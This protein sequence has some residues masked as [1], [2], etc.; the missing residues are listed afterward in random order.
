MLHVVLLVG[1]VAASGYTSTLI[2]ARV[3]ADVPTPSNPPRRNFQSRIVPVTPPIEYL[4]PTKNVR[5]VVEG[6]AP[7]RDG[8]RARYMYRQ[9]ATTYRLF[10]WYCIPYGKLSCGSAQMVSRTSSASDRAEDTREVLLMTITSS[11]VSAVAVP[12]NAGH[13]IVQ[14]E[15]PSRDSMY[16]G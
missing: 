1:V 2:H 14:A 9:L 6:G 15:A 12:P 8:S 11:T 7:Y 4:L 10:L 16:G 3:A 13:V 5:A